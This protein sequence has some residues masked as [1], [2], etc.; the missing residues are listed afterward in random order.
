MQASDNYVLL[1][2]MANITMLSH[3][4]LLILF[5]PLSVTEQ[6]ASLMLHSSLS[7]LPARPLL[8]FAT[9]Y[10]L[11]SAPYQYCCQYQYV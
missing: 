1:K 6:Y 2:R 4:S 3:R 9:T 5:V 11:E 10:T 8:L 7:K